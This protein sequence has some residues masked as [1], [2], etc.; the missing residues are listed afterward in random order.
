MPV[1]EIESKTLLRKSKKIDSWFLSR[2]GMNLYRGCLHDCI[3]C[4]GRAEKYNV[5]GD[6][7]KD[8]AVKVNAI[9]LLRRE[10]SPKRKRIPFKK[11]YVMIG[12]G[13]GDS[14]Q[15]IEEKYKLTRQALELV[16]EHNF[17]AHVLT[18]S[19]L[20]KRDIDILKKIDEKNR[21]I[22]SFSLSSADE[23]LSSIFEPNVPPPQ[24]RLDTIRLLKREGLSC[25]MFLMPVIPLL[26]DTKEQMENTL[27]KA[28][29]SGVDF[30][31]FGGMTLKTGRQK[32]YFYNV[33]KKHYPKLI[34]E[35]DN[36]YSKSSKYGEADYNYYK[37]INW[38]FNNATKK[39]DVPKRIPLRLYKDILEENDLVVVILDHLDYYL[40]INRRDST[41]SRAGYSVS[42]LKEPLSTMRDRL[43]GLSWV[44]ET[45]KNIIIEILDTGTSSYLEKL[46]NSPYY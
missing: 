36:L 35:Y 23:K 19:T 32:D 22:V 46:E 41:Y 9:N 38:I 15:P 5:K 25:G 16:Y 45:T 8:V 18:K 24:E 43:T 33:L 42:R 28:K 39:F 21:A 30:I 17:P 34:T 4:D 44:G 37:S 14:Y 7:E 40:K 20:V 13:V 12:G 10:L 2:Y 27:K 6:F 11:C 3:Y 1:K 26:S 31:I 29:E